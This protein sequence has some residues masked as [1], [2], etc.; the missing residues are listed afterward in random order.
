MRGVFWFTTFLTSNPSV[1]REPVLFFKYQRSTIRLYWVLVIV[2]VV[3]Y[4]LLFHIGF[5]IRADR[6]IVTLADNIVVIVVIAVAT[7]VFNTIVSLHSI[8][9]NWLS[10]CCI[11][12]MPLSTSFIW[13][14]LI[15][16]HTPIIPKSQISLFTTRIVSRL[17]NVA[18]IFTLY[19]F[20]VIIIFNPTLTCT[21]IN[22]VDPWW[23]CRLSVWRVISSCYSLFFLIF[24]LILSQICV[25][26]IL[27]VL[28]SW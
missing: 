20:I 23:K 14:F 15:H 3:L 17:P 25:W 18:S 26:W 22:A 11:L 12:L 4:I 5:N 6:I 10:E 28:L 7:F 1:W 21:L 24:R 16:F 19:F 2:S 27:C 8:Y 9:V 13:I